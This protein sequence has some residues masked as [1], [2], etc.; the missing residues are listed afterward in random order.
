MDDGI[1]KGK[2]ETDKGKE[3]PHDKSKEEEVDVKEED[4]ITHLYEELV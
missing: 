4:S 3:G 1:A 2:P